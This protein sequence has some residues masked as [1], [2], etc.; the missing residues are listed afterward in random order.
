MKFLRRGLLCVLALATLCRA[1]NGQCPRGTLKPFARGTAEA[2]YVTG[3]VDQEALGQLGCLAML[4][5][6][7]AKQYLAFIPQHQSRRRRFA[8]FTAHLMDPS[9]DKG[10]CPVK[11]DRFSKNLGGASKTPWPPPN[12]ASATGQSQ[13]DETTPPN[14]KPPPPLF[15][16]SSATCRRWLGDMLFRRQKGLLTF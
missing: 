10:A 5:T 15:A 6:D 14:P 13:T 2:Q 16:S 1:E 11:A 9:W 3:T 7:D 4:V 8:G 12:S